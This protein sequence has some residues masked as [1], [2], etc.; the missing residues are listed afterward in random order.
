MQYNTLIG[1]GELCVLRDEY[2]PIIRLSDIFNIDVEIN[3]DNTGLLVVVEAEGNKIGLYVDDLLAQQQVVIKSLETN[4]MKVKG[5]SGATILG[6]GVVAMILD[7]SGLMELTNL[8]SG[9]K[10]PTNSEITIAN[11]A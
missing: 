4:F 10:I 9:P 1:R 8:R 5:V 7:I 6:D 2:I 3:D 11:V